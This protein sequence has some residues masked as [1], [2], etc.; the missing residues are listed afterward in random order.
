M[1]VPGEHDHDV[2]ACARAW[3]MLRMAH[4]RVAH[5]LDAALSRECGLAI[6]EFDALLYL[7]SHRDGSVRLGSLLEAVSLSQPAL[8]RLVARL[9]TRGLLTRSPADDDRRAS[10]V[11]LSETGTALIDRAVAIHARVVHETLTS[12]FTDEEQAA[13]LH[14]LSRIGG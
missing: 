3:Q 1:D 6:H 13:L 14:T 9:E 11:T 5:R 12:K 4:E 2:G 8:S 10:I 7:R